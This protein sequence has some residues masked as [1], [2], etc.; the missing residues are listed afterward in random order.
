MKPSSLHAC[1]L[2]LFY[3]WNKW[4]SE[5]FCTFLVRVRRSVKTLVHWHLRM[6]PISTR[7]FFSFQSHFQ[8]LAVFR[9]LRKLKLI[10]CYILLT[11]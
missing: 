8:F 4:F 7:Y 3:S 10:S 6:N 1:P 9:M 11:V 2:N 5:Y